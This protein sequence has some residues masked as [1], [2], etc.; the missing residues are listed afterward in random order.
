MSSHVVQYE[1]W[2]EC[3]CKCTFCTL[4]YDNLHT[5][6][7]LKL[8]SL[9]TA[10]DEIKEMKAGEHETL[11][12]IGGE[13]FQGQLSTEELRAKWFELMNLCNDVLN[14]DIV[15]TIWINASLLIGSQPDF[16]KT[17]DLFD[18]KNQVWVLTSFDTWGRF[19]TQKMFDTWEGHL[20]KIHTEYPEVRVNIT[21]I[22]TGDFINK[23]LNNELDIHKYTKKYGYTIF[24]KNPVQPL[25]EDDG[26]PNTYFNDILPNFFPKR[27]DM[28][29][30]FS[31][32]MEMY[33]V[34]EYDRLIS[35][36]L[37]ADEIRKNY[38]NDNQRNLRYT[39]NRETLQEFQE[40]DANPEAEIMEC[41]H[42]NIYKSYIDSD[43]CILCDKQFIRKAMGNL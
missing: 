25:I 20:E 22:I 23:F 14:K 37:R 18:K 43:K 19:H 6:N 21:S 27:N 17:L 7:S 36:D 12:F 8:Q 40:D 38:N 1:L 13:F 15:Q 4:G 35:T 10:I 24:L 11:G 31:K 30:F 16:Y 26:V 39:R 41:G 9:Q 32:Y 29:K 2:R 34:D 33:G 3:N 42:N 28:L 5:D